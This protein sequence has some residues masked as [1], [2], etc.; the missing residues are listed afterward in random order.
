MAVD[1]VYNCTGLKLQRN[2]HSELFEFGN[3]ALEDKVAW[4]LDKIR[5]REAYT[6]AMTLLQA[7]FGPGQP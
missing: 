5:S 3:T 1:R 4:D 2:S 6:Q 7:T